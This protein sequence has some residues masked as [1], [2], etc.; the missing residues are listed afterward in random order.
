MSAVVTLKLSPEQFDMLRHAVEFA[1]TVKLEEAH[2]S[3]NLAE[4]D[5]RRRQHVQFK[6]VLAALNRS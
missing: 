4:K 5:S 1:A 2:I 3:K 6:D